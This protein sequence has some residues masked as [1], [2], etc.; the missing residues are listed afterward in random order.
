MTWPLE[1][2]TS[3]QQQPNSKA[4]G[5]PFHPVY[6][7]VNALWIRVNAIEVHAGHAREH[8]DRLE[9]E[10]SRLR[11]AVEEV[12]RRINHAVL[13]LALGAGGLLL[14]LIGPKIG[15]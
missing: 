7:Q 11:E 14:K 3:T 13:W 8:A 6:E 15:L 5:G 9:K 12:N 2:G 10:Q 4:I 1:P